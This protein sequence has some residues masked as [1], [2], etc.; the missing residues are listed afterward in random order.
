MHT[1]SSNPTMKEE[2]IREKAPSSLEIS[3]PATATH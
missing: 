2:G 1:N 3:L